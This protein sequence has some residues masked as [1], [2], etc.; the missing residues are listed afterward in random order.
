M[1]GRPPAPEGRP[2][3]KTAQGRRKAASGSPFGRSFA[4]LAGDDAWMESTAGPH[5]HPGQPPGDRG[6]GRSKSLGGDVT[7]NVNR[8]MYTVA[9][10]AD[11]LGIGRS[12]AYELVVRG[13]LGATRIGGRWLISR[14]VLAGLIGERPPL[15]RELNRAKDHRARR[16]LRA[17]RRGRCAARCGRLSCLASQCSAA[18][19]VC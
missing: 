19:N 17:H 3:R 7:T 9:E 18:G 16:W 11:V 1:E 12:T 5:A 2:W 14:S 13:E 4:A 15:P 6:P 10:A 8:R